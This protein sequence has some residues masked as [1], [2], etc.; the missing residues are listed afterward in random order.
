MTIRELDESLVRPNGYKHFMFI[1]ARGGRRDYESEVV[2]IHRK[3]SAA[4]RAMREG[5]HVWGWDS[6]MNP[7]GGY[8]VI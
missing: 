3:S 7:D 4:K 2:S 8:R 6:Y 5:E 1:V